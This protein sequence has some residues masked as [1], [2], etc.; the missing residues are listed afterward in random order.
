MECQ[1]GPIGLMTYD[2]EYKDRGAD[3]LM[4]HQTTVLGTRGGGH[5][6]ID[7]IQTLHLD[8]WEERYVLTFIGE[9]VFHPIKS[10]INY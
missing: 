2:K 1:F 5:S 10:Y 8:I 6:L 4:V 9:N 3:S 7:Y